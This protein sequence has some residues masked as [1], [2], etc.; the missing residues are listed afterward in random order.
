MQS[1]ARSVEQPG[2]RRA[3][4]RPEEPGPRSSSTRAST[5]AGRR[6]WSGGRR[7][8]HATTGA[9][10]LGHRP[11]AMRPA[12]GP[13]PPVPRSRPG[14][15][16]PGAPRILHL[17]GASIA[18]AQTP[19][20]VSP[21]PT[22]SASVCCSDA[23]FQTPKARTAASRRARHHWPGACRLASGRPP[24]RPC[25]RGWPGQACS[26]ARLAGFRA[27]PSGDHEI[28][29]DRQIGRIAEP[30]HQSLDAL[31]Q[32]LGTFPLASKARSG[33]TIA[34]ESTARSA[35]ISRP[36]RPPKSNRPACTSGIQDGAS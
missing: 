35:K 9:W 11:R 3:R 8:S 33:L 14:A 10:F 22:S 15:R 4:P 23:M 12:P 32:L 29:H 36:G 16:R 5:I 6:L 13:G 31:V 17:D 21:A 27:F 1:L 34:G 7:P 28:E 26:R 20:A 25:G 19:R 18:A 30:R 24:G 2:A